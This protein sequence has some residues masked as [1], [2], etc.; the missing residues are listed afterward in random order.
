MC[1]LQRHHVEMAVTLLKRG[2]F[3]DI[4]L[5]ELLEFLINA[6]SSQGKHTQL[7]GTILE[8]VSSGISP[9]SCSSGALVLKSYMADI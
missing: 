8:Q 6:R 9:Y 5:P 1:K 4:G 7:L 2:I 3:K